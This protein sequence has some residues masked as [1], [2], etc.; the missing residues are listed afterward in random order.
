METETSLPHEQQ[1]HT[2]TY[3]EPDN[4]CHK[5]SR[6]FKNHFNIIIPPKKYV[7]ILLYCFISFVFYF[8]CPAICIFL[9]MYIAVL[10]LCTSLWLTATGWKTNFSK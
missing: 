2:L 8:V 4:S 5:Q 10:V 9:L 7:L 6:Y 3:P 1:P